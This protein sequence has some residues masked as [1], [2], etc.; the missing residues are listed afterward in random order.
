MESG[1]WQNTYDCIF[2]RLISPYETN[3][4]RTFVSFCS[5]CS[6]H[7]S[8]YNVQLEILCQRRMYNWKSCVSAECAT[9]SRVSVQNVQL[10][11][12]C[13]RRMSIVCLMFLSRTE[14]SA[15]DE[16]FHCHDGGCMLLE[17]VCDGY[18]DCDDG[19]DEINCGESTRR[20]RCCRKW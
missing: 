11:V 5:D 17:Y 4:H 7:R 15:E 3:V 16:K 6:A 1:C 14:C 19:S 18:N 12:V 9:G 8:A 10:E 13:Q 20:L 2:R